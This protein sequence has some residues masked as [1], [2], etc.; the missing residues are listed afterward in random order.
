MGWFGFLLLLVVVAGGIYFY[1][2]LLVIEQEIRREH[3]E[4]HARPYDPAD[5]VVKPEVA[6][7][8]FREQVRLEPDSAEDEEKEP[9]SL[10]EA[11]LKVINDLPGLLQTELYA[12]FPGEERKRL[13]AILL[14]LDR[15]G[16][17]KREKK[18][19]SYRV[20]LA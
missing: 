6:P 15:D 17:I 18:K 12:L 5:A 1:Q 14:R 3:A 13:Q 11:L 7:P 4:L 16:K 10:E 2:K 9:V 8:I 20:F 19:S